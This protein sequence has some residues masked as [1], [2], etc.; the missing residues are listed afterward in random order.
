[1]GFALFPPNTLVR[2]LSRRIGRDRKRVRKRIRY[3][4]GRGYVVFH[5]KGRAVNPSR[6]REILELVKEFE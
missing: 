4:A 5:E 1:V 6:S 3:L 2:W